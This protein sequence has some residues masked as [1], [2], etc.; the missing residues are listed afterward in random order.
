MFSLIVVYILL[1]GCTTFD[2]KWSTNRSLFKANTENLKVGDII[3]TTKDWSSP[4]SW[5]G[6]SAVMVSK[7]KVGEYPDRKSVV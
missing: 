3:I 4:M 7:H 6:H 5:F 1:S 2:E